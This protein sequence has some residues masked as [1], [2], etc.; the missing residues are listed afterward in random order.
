M[1]ETVSRTFSPTLAAKPLEYNQNYSLTNDSTS[2]YLII[3]YS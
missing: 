3:L 2:T 1:A